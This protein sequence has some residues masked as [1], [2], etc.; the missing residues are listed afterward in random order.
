M[1]D[2]NSGSEL[3]MLLHDIDKNKWSAL[4]KFFHQRRN[5]GSLVDMIDYAEKRLVGWEDNSRFQVANNFHLLSN[6]ELSP[7]IRLIRHLKIA[8]KSEVWGSRYL[9]LL[10][11]SSYAENLRSLSIESCELYSGT[12]QT[13]SNSNGFKNL[14]KLVIKKTFSDKGEMDAIAYSNLLNHLKVLELVG[15]RINDNWIRIFLSRSKFPSLVNLN[16]SFNGITD[17]GALLLSKAPLWKNLK[18]LDLKRNRISGK[19]RQLIEASGFFPKGTEF[20]FE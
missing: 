2:D 16:L 3:N 17:I 9:K 6:N 12:L 15:Q 7:S 11:Q 8:R 20:T 10:S 19:G 13:L 14:D 4:F 5:D 1:L 18:S